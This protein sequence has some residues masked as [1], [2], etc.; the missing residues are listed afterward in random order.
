MGER[1]NASAAE[2][3]FKAEKSGPAFKVGMRIEK[4]GRDAV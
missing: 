3:T 1:A 2:A 4:R